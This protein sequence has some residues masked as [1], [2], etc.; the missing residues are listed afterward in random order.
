MTPQLAHDYSFETLWSTG[1][2][3]SI[4]EAIRA[5]IAQGSTE[6]QAWQAQI[7]TQLALALAMQQKFADAHQQLDDATLCAQSSLDSISHVRIALE[8]GRVFHQAGDMPSARKLFEQAQLLGHET[9]ALFYLVDAL[10][11]LAIIADSLEEKLNWNEKA[12]A[13]AESG[14]CERS[15]RWLGSLWNNKGQW[16]F[17]LEQWEGSFAAYETAL[18]YR[19]VEEYLPNIRFA[20]W[21]LARGHRALGRFEQAIMLL[22]DLDATYRVMHES[23][24]YDFPE[25]LYTM[26][27]GMVLEELAL[28]H[29]SLTQMHAKSGLDLLEAAPIVSQH[30][31]HRIEQ[32]RSLLQNAQIK[33]MV[34]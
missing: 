6:P 13:I 14:R 19:I 8:R 18:Q 15:Q 25:P 31:P 1:I 28:A 22:R 34:H 9:E 26:F 10:H 3:A 21:T 20:Q 32:L 7:R 23:K 5:A 17:Q 27:H 2:P 30:E 4:E 24:K 29:W 16:L 12:I 33:N 11:M